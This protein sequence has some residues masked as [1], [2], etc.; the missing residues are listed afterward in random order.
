MN[1]YGIIDPQPENCNHKI[2][3]AKTSIVLLPGQRT[4]TFP[5]HVYGICRFCGKPFHYI[6]DENGNLTIYKKEVDKNADNR[7]DKKSIK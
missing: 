4:F 3:S 2:N 7:T 6:R 5:E 1:E